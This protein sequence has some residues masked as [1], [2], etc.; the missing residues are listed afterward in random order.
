MH[1][2]KRIKQCYKNNVKSFIFTQI[3]FLNNERHIKKY[4]KQLKTFPAQ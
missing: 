3:T 2:F 1:Y 4:K